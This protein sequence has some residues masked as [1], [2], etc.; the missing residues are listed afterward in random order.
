[1]AK[2]I[3]TLRDAEEAYEAGDIETTLEIC[4]G[5]I[6][7]DETK[8]PPEVLY[9]AGECLLEL[10]EEGEALHMFELALAADPENP[11]LLHCKGLCLFE[12]GRAAEAKALFQE[13]HERAPELAEPVFYLGLV[14]EREGKRAEANAQFAAAVELDPEN[15]VMPRKWDA[16]DVRAAFDGM[17]EETPEPLSVWL[18]GLPIEVEGSPAGDVLVRDGEPI[19]PLVHCLF[20]GQGSDGPSGDDPARWLSARPTRVVLYTDNLGKSAQDEYELS[21]EVSEAVLWELMEFLSLEEEH[22]EALGV[23]EEDDV[24]DD[25]DIHPSGV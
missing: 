17:V 1:M 16:E 18:A 2:D 20:F 10:Q 22:L 4:D 13:A 11:L 3:P 8:A 15:F 19:S 7:E 25:E 21:R 6:G 24:E 5:I 9:L 12:L 23:L 14:L